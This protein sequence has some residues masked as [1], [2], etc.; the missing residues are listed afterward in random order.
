MDAESDPL[1]L[2]RLL[3]RLPR[4]DSGLSLMAKLLL[5]VI[6]ELERVRVGDIGDP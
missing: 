1:R 5:L 3:F 2:C 6:D 4:A